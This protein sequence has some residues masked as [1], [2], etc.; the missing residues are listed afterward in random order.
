[1][2]PILGILSHCLEPVI[3]SHFKLAGHETGSVAPS[4]PQ[5]GEEEGYRQDTTE[6]RNGFRLEKW[7]F[8]KYVRAVETRF[9]QQINSGVELT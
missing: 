2:T 1:M 7:L 4:A 5:H 9:C 3:S 6:T 8:L